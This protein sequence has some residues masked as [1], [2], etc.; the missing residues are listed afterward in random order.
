MF[1]LRNKKIIFGYTLLT[2]VL[3]MLA[4]T[5]YL[6]GGLLMWMMPMHLHVNQKSDCDND[7]EFQPLMDF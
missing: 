6:E 3:T 7:D 2:K 1:W 4:L 5:S